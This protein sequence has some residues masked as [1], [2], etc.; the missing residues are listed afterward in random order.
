[1]KKFVYLRI[2]ASSHVL[3]FLTV[4]SMSYKIEVVKK[5]VLGL[6]FGLEP[7]AFASLLGEVLAPKACI[8]ERVTFAI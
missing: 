1:M 4:L 2:A 5:L 6:Y 7:I 3:D 8:Y